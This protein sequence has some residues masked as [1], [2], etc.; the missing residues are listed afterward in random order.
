MTPVNHG[1]SPDDSAEAVLAAA[2]GAA[3]YAPSIHNTQPWHW[4]NT[5]S[6]L[7][8]SADR[9]RQLHASDPSGRMLT[10]SCGASLAYA[11][12]AIAAQGRRPLITRV[13][14]GDDPDTLAT[15]SAGETVEHHRD[16]AEWFRS[17]MRRQ[18]DRRPLIE[19]APTGAE[20]EAMRLEAERESCHL[21]LLRS[22]QVVRLASAAATASRLETHDPGRQRELAEWVAVGE[23]SPGVP[24]TTIPSAGGR[25]RVPPR[26][27]S[28][29]L[30][31]GGSGADSA[32]AYLLLF[33]DDDDRSAW[34]R[35]GEAMVGAWVAAND[36]GLAVMP[37][38][39][40]VEIAAARLGLYRLL[41]GIG[42]P[43]LILR[44]GHPDTTAEPPL[45]PREH[46]VPVPA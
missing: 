16:Q 26:F 10:I 6:Q 27:Q 9:D 37:L 2:A 43:Q 1:Y 11:R 40:V 34:L 23:D 38:S 4:T 42:H 15:V 12:A 46:V 45:T 5:G 31:T 19:P 35:A 17:M 24:D 3:R 18:T 22:D 39:S 30:P 13:P 33:T 32:G 7:V 20:I 41:S 36:A 8:L 28:G 29:T 21:Q 14:T 44:A 25:Y